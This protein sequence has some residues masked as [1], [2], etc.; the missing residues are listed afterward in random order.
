M[1][2]RGCEGHPVSWR[3]FE[4]VE[5]DLDR[6]LRKTSMKFLPVVMGLLI[7]GSVAADEV[8]RNGGLNAGVRPVFAWDFSDSGFRSA[9]GDLSVG[10]IHGAPT[11]EVAGP[12]PPEFPEFPADNRALMLDGRSRLEIS[13]PGESMLDFRESDAIAIEAWVQ[14]SALKNGQQVYVIGKGRTGRPGMIA[15]NQNWALRLRGMDG[16]ARVSFLFRSADT[17]GVVDQTGSETVKPIPG[18]L[19]R[20]NSDLGFSVDGQWHHVV[21]SFRFGSKSSPMAWLDG[22]PTDGTWDLGAKTYS[23][24]PHVDNDQV[25]IG[26]ALGGNQS[27]SFQGAIDNLCVYRSELKDA[28]VQFRYRSTRKTYWTPETASGDLPAGSVL[29]DIREHVRQSTPWDRERTRISRQWQQPAAAL[30]RLPR[31]YQ[32]GGII[33]DRSGPV[34]VRMRTMLSTAAVKTQFLIRARSAS[35]LLIDGVEVATLTPLPYASDGHQEVPV[36]PEPLYPGMH[37]VPAGD[38]E[39]IADV[40]LTAGPHLVEFEALA[41][42]KNMRVEIS[43][44]LV[45]MGSVTNG[46]EVISPTDFSY[47]LEEQSWRGLVARQQEFLADLESRDRREKSEEDTTWW[48]QRHALVGALIGD[49][50]ARVS[51]RDIDQLVES[52][53]ASRGLA[54]TGLVDDFTFLRR[55]SLNTVGVIPSLKEREWFFAQPVETRRDRAIDRYLLDR[56]WADH[57]VPYWQDVLAENPGILKPE[58]NN[59]G[60]FRWWI[61][62]SFLDNKAT[63]RFATELILMKG[64][65]LGGGPAGF[66]M[67]SQNDVPMAERAIVLMSAFS[68]QNLKCARCHDSPVNEV[69]QKQLFEMS[70]LLNRASITIPKTSS[71]PKGPNGE[72]SPLITVSIEPGTSVSPAWP[73]A[74]RGTPD[75][76]EEHWVKLLRDVDDPREQVALHLTHPT[77]SEFAKV[78]VNR[79][80]ARLFGQGLVQNPED[81]YGSQTEHAELLELLSRQH[82]ASGYDLKATAR[83]ILKTQAWQRQVAPADAP[84][85]KFFGAV[86]MRRMSAEQMLDSLYV[87]A[88]KSFDSEMLTLDPEGRRPDESFLNLGTPTRAWQLCSLSNER[89]RPALALPVAQS[90]IDLLTVFGWRDSRPHSLTE[91]DEQATVLQPLTLAN[92]N[93]GHRL[94]QLSDNTV[95][96]ELALQA[97]S[98]ES[99]VELLFRMILTR[100]PEQEEAAMFVGELNFGFDDR[101]VSGAVKNPVTVRRNAVSWSNH[102]NSEATRLKQE[103]E[104]AARLGDLPTK[105]LTESWRMA[106]EDVIWVLMNSPEFA[107]VP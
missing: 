89:D 88:G 82:M 14:V 22:E 42:G 46:F 97:D 50:A 45:A 90:L 26:S 96:T 38:Q 59:S 48:E 10:G 1:I 60:P 78:M 70:A 41:G 28:D 40:E 61:H 12:R 56:R 75:G 2:G 100:P 99:M 94:V 15:E 105:R 7:C 16:T 6:V 23:R 30:I 107:F 17:P 87:A 21:V 62:E 66:A 55:L 79:L 8:K 92:G 47:R 106:A 34:V 84:V 11:T 18:E 104:E 13:D 44:T 31:K 77:K 37:P 63:D 86:T 33:G 51:S 25:W 29:L 54:P 103:Q 3:S 80:W 93:A 58:L 71:V 32:E 83:L 102:L 36:P 64:S 95:T 53:L 57:W 85:A 52:G 101:V 19:H 4:V 69:S 43:E 91:R 74:E 98:P 9:V 72:R 35:R 67:A 27:N 65:V 68:A 73:F 76:S 39:V 49:D 81:W 5:T 20:W 24:K